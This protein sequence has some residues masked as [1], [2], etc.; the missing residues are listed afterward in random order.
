MNRTTLRA[1]FQ[2]ALYQ[3]LDNAGFRIL[4]ALFLLPV[5]LSFAV[6]FR[7]TS[8]SFLWIWEWD[9]GD[10]VRSATASQGLDAASRATMLEGVRERLL[11]G[12]VDLVIKWGADRFGF[13]FG[14][15]AISFFVPQML[16][17]GSADV[18]FSKPVSRPALFFSRYVA[19]LIFVGI[20]ST[21]LVG[22]ITLG[23]LVSSSW[24]DAGLLW[25][26]F[27]LMY[28]FAVFHA[29]S[30][31]IGVFTRNAIAS[32]LL[33]LVFMPVNCGLHTGW[34]GLI[35]IERATEG[36]RTSPQEEEPESGA[37]AVL[38]TGLTTY[39]VLAPKTGDAMRMARSWRRNFE[40]QPEFE[41][42]ELGLTVTEAPRGFRREPRSSFAGDGLQWLAAHPDGAGEAHWNLRR[43]KLSESGSRSALVK[44]LRKELGADPVRSDISSRYA[45]RFE[46]VEDRGGEK[47]LRRRWILQV[48][49]NIVTLD[50]DAESGWA[51]A[52]EQENAATAFVAGLAIRSE[53]DRLMTANSYDSRFGWSGAWQ[54]NAWFSLGTTL[55]FTALVLALGVWK[56][57]RI[58]F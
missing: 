50:Y 5:L 41:D 18:I 22:G 55:L 37:F 28:G 11:Q 24:F 4:L 58:D 19:G 35:V 56:L 32:I 40:E 8:I 2:D 25:S 38:K 57:R 34:E 30:C 12:I 54:Y 29:I 9:Y 45:D 16:E 44:K 43:Q 33:T 6:S 52:N 53:E 7:E 26:V 31:T 21:L 49:D 10:F 51:R 3:V 27:A 14:I 46:W 48:G 15:A 17:R 20:L 23:L 1:L 39:H 36:A 13:V 47:R 42:A